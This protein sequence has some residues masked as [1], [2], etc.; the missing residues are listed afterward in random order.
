MFL[1]KHLVFKIYCDT[2]FKWIPI[3]L[4][5]RLSLN[6][7]RDT[8]WIFFQFLQIFYAETIADIHLMHNAAL[9]W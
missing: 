2:L 9:K 3:L 5:T 8:I 6:I 1:K 7:S 4:Y